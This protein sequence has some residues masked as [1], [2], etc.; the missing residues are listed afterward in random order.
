MTREEKVRKNSLL[1]HGASWNQMG[2]L[3]REIERE[4]IFADAV[5]RNLHFMALQETGC[6]SY[7]KFIGRGGVI[8]NLEGATREY[9]GLGFYISDSWLDKLISAKLINDR[10]AVI[11]FDLGKRGF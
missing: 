6:K 10:I 2:Q 11:K 7:Q 5:E 1:T 3:D 8:I 4:Q 9:R